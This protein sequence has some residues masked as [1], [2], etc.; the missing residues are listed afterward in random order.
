MTFRVLSESS[1][2][3]RF[4]VVKFTRPGQIAEKFLEHAT[5]VSFQILSDSSFPSHPNIGRH[6]GRVTD[7]VVK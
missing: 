4:L 1:A 7:N 3:L 5:I 2:I 6:K